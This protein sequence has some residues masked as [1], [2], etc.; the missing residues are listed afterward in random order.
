[1]NKYAY[2]TRKATKI[3]DK[4]KQRLIKN[5]SSMVENYGQKEIRP[6]IDELN[7]LH[8]GLTYQEQCG[9]KAILYSVKDLN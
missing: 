9:I 7:G 6:L 2:Y 5:P 1:M 3:I 4:L 8:S